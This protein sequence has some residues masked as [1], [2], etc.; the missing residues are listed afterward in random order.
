MNKN[1]G[2]E[3]LNHPMKIFLHNHI[4]WIALEIKKKNYQDLKKNIKNQESSVK[5]LCQGFDPQ[6]IHFKFFTKFPR[7]HTCKASSIHCKKLEKYEKGSRY[8]G[9]SARYFRRG[10]K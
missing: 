6:N 8:I 2:F 3:I 1:C 10:D 7:V 9:V 5:I 4:I